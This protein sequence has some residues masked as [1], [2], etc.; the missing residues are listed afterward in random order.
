[1]SDCA[2]TESG[3]RLPKI[4]ADVSV[5]VSSTF[6]DM[7]DERDFSLGGKTLT[8]RFIELGLSDDVVGMAYRSECF[9]PSTHKHV[10]GEDIDRLE[11]RDR[12]DLLYAS[13]EEFRGRYEVS[14]EILGSLERSLEY[15]IDSPMGS[16]VN[17]RLPWEE[18][19]EMVREVKP[20]RARAIEVGVFDDKT[21]VEGRTDAKLAE[22]A[23]ANKE[24]RCVYAN[25]TGHY[26][27]L[28]ERETGLL[29]RY[30]RISRELKKRS[31]RCFDARE[32][33]HACLL[34]GSQDQRRVCEV[35]AYKALLEVMRFFPSTRS[36][37]RTWSYLRGERRPPE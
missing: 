10:V 21:P 18:R 29:K 27:Y 12:L 19:L 23:A 9:M 34:I 24:L 1:M 11:K 26:D 8:E 3:A 35:E 37:R 22:I 6:R 5:F 33:A 17:Y 31:S 7:Q 20:A 16:I 15:R 13:Y 14:D 32:H 4:P 36:L 25:L 28:E 2:V 30:L